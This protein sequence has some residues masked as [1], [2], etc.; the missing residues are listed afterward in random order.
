MR[1]TT[2]GGVPSVG[3]AVPAA[4]LDYRAP[5]L[6]PCPVSHAWDSPRPVRTQASKE[7]NNRPMEH[8]DLP[9]VFGVARKFWE[10]WE[11]PVDKYRQP[12]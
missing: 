3:G 12:L 4:A 6:V 8:A 11:P 5:H 2:S 10:L 1:Q 7:L 9:P